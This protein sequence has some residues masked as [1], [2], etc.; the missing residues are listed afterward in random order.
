MTSLFTKCEN[1]KISVLE[2]NQN[3]VVLLVRRTARCNLVSGKVFLYYHID[4]NNEWFIR[5][6]LIII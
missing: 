1:D 3:L 4:K 6:F 2:S 5:F